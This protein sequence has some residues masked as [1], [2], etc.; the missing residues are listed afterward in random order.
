MFVCVWIE[1][2]ISSKRIKVLENER[3]WVLF[4][5]EK[6]PKQQ[7]RHQKW[8]RFVIVRHLTGFSRV[9]VASQVH[10]CLLRVNN[11]RLVCLCL[12]RVCRRVE[13]VVRFPGLPPRRQ[14][15]YQAKQTISREMEQEKMRRAEQLM[16]LRNPAPVRLGH[17]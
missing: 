7:P 12:L 17:T 15:T 4:C 5:G 16:L 1:L 13:E 2:E 11:E 14:L 10:L 3:F 6:K 9:S 8:K